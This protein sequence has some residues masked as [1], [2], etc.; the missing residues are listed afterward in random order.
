MS[1]LLLNKIQLRKKM[2]ILCM[3][4]RKAS[5]ETVASLTLKLKK[6]FFR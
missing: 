5:G 6:K 2:S 4:A 1:L 3:T